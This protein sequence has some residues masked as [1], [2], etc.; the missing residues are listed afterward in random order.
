MNLSLNSEDKQIQKKRDL[1][2]IMRDFNHKIW[3]CLS[4][5]FEDDNLITFRYAITSLLGN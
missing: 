4:I 1:Q 5:S 2:S 3:Y